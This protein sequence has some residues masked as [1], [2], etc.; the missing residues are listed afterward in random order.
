[1]VLELL[2][3]FFC[4]NAVLGL[5]SRRKGQTSTTPTQIDVAA[6]PSAGRGVPGD[7]AADSSRKSCS[8]VGTVSLDEHHQ[9]ECATVVC[10]SDGDFGNVY[11][12]VRCSVAEAASRHA[13]L[14]KGVG[15]SVICR[16]AIANEA[17][18][19]RSICDSKSAT[20]ASAKRRR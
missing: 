1:V 11:Y 2:F 19:C 4:L 5:E 12:I 20:P 16:T 15:E 10:E 3:F 17:G 6:S 8:P 7:S 14:I 18:G 13:K 9:R